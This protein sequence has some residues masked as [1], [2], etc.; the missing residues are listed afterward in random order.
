MCCCSHPEN[1]ELP[2]EMPCCYVGRCIDPFCTVQQ[3]HL[4]H[5]CPK[6]SHDQPISWIAWKISVSL[7]FVFFFSLRPCL[8]YLFS[9]FSVIIAND[10]VVVSS[11]FLSLLK[12]LERVDGFLPNVIS[13]TVTRLEAILPLYIL[14]S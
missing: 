6:D 3:P 13:T 2:A 8:C 11:T 14:K 5:R 7:R 9:T 4:P 1:V 10:M 12:N